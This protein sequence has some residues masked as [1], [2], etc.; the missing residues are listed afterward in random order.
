MNL[1]K[2]EE[3][4]GLPS[5]LLSSV[6]KTESGGDPNAVSPKGALGAFQFLPETAAQYGINPLDPE[7][8][9]VGAAEMYS[10]LLNKYQGD[11]P[12]ALAAY[13]WGQGNLDRKGMQNAPDETRNYIQRVMAGM[14]GGQQM[15]DDGTGYAAPKQSLAASALSRIG[16]M[17]VPS[18]QASEYVAQAP[19]YGKEPDYSKMTDEQLQ[20]IVGQQQPDNGLLAQVNQF[21]DS[22]K[23]LGAEPDYSTMTD[24]QLQ[25]IAAGHE[26]KSAEEPGFFGRS[27]ADISGRIDEAKKISG[28]YDINN[29][30]NALDFTKRALQIGGKTV[31]GGVGDVL[32]EGAVSAFKTLPDS[33]QNYLKEHIAAGVAPY[34]DEKTPIG[35]GIKHLSDAY[36]GLSPDTK[37]SL[38]ATGDVA[39]FFPLGKGAK[40]ANSADRLGK[41][42]AVAA[43]DKLI[44]SG[45]NLATKYKE[46]FNPPIKEATPTADSIKAL[47]SQYYKTADEKG[48]LLMPK[49]TDDFVREAEKLAPQT[50]AGLLTAGETAATQ[51][52]KRWQALKGKSITLAGAQEMDEALSGIINKEYGLKGLSKE[53][54]QIQE[55]Q[56]KFRDMMKDAAK[57]NQIGGGK[58]GFEAWQKGQELWSKQASMRDIENIISQSANM[59]NPAQALKTRFNTLLNNK[60]RIAAYKNDPATYAAIKSAAKTGAVTG[61]LRIFGSR[62]IP[63]AAGTAEG[64]GGGGI[65]GGLIAGT[66]AHGLSSLSRNAATKL[67]MR[68]AN[69][70]LGAIAARKVKK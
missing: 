61:L 70:V 25:A 21:I 35:A 36:G 29:D 27:L 8:A 59:E 22:R 2:L 41:D 15:A 3:Q 33:A 34:F 23:P 55:I 11:V 5:G 66:A 24:E 57:N 47:S 56:D 37:T 51:L 43:T 26:A 16:E 69:K 52:I 58:E 31:F 63:I 67:Q 9:A 19:E 14:G 1:A 28:S 45:E 12:S 38:E 40:I 53:G 46:A 13:N 39:A 18:A 6:Q 20:T 62:L 42:L 50:E 32:K 49:F 68:K 7:Q 30:P 10:E 44:G 17:I 4:Y 60:K 54:F 48:G 65:T 64:V